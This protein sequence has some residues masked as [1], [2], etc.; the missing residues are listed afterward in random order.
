MIDSLSALKDFFAAEAAYVTAG[1][2][3]KA[4]F[5]GMAAHLSPDVVMYQAESLPYGGAWTGPDGIE[6]FMAAMSEAWTSLEFLEQRF[7]AD[8]P[9][10]VV[11]NRGVLRARATGRALETSVM[12]WFTFED[13][14]ISEI[15]PFYLDTAAVLDVLGTAAAL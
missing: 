11:R 15:R 4:D 1:G 9:V 3:G 6:R 2:P 8:G 10:A 13:G 12:Q 14:L 5:A 7:A